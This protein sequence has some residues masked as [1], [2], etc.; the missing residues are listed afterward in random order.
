MKY[1]VL[2]SVKEMDLETKRT[3]EDLCLPTEKKAIII[4]YVVGMSLSY[5]YVR[6]DLFSFYC[7][8]IGRIVRF[9]NLRQFVSEE[10]IAGF[11][12]NIDDHDRV[13]IGDFVTVRGYGNMVFHVTNKVSDSKYEVSSSIRNV[14]YKTVVSKN[15]ICGHSNPTYYL[16]TNIDCAEPED[17]LVIDYDYLKGSL[18]L[19]TPLDVLNFLIRL[20]VQVRKKRV[21]FSFSSEEDLKGPAGV[22]AALLGLSFSVGG[23]AKG[24]YFLTNRGHYLWFFDAIINICSGLCKDDDS[25]DNED[26]G[27]ILFDRNY[28]DLEK[29]CLYYMLLDLCRT[30]DLPLLLDTDETRSYLSS[31]SWP[32]INKRYSKWKTLFEDFKLRCE[33]SLVIPQSFTFDVDKFRKYVDHNNLI[34]LLEN[35]DFYVNVLRG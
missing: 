2:S 14:D 1:L 34:W 35:F 16:Y 6:E 24:S 21:C 11:C 23:V 20:K 19:E 12:K 8:K 18:P 22:V 25:E 10:E 3:L 31:A 9:Y 13:S 30:K 32:E 7:K 29:H 26:Y 28:L 4:P 15:I 5:I 33:R 27:I 17:N